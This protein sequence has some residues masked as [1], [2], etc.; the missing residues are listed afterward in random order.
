MAEMERVS[1]VSKNAIALVTA[2]LATSGLSF[3]MAIIINKQLGP[4]L[5]GVYNFAFVIYMI[6]QV[7]PDFGIGN[8][9]IRDVSQD[10]AKLHYYFRN[11]VGLR[12][13]LGLAAFILLTTTNLITLAAQSPGGIGAEKFWAVFVIGFCFFIEQ[14]FS[15][16]LVENFIAL[17]RLTVVA[18]VYLV[19]GILKVGL[20]IYVV[21][22]GFNN[23]V[24]W[25]ILIY[26]FTLLYSV[27]HF[28]L[29]YSRLLK[30]QGELKSGTW[31]KAAAA[32]LLKVPETGEVPQEALAAE[33]A[34]ASAMAAET[35]DKV[36]FEAPSSGGAGTA[37]TDPEPAKSHT[38]WR[39]GRFFDRELWLYLLRSAWP[40]AVVSSAITIYAIVDVPILSWMKGD[41]VVGLYAAAAM[42]A[43]AF[44][45]LTIAINMAVLPA[46]SKVGGKHPEKLGPTWEKLLFYCVVVIAPLMV[47]TP[48]LARPVL[49][50]EGFDYI[51]AW[52][53]VWLSMAAMV[54]TFMEA[55]SFSFFIVI[56]KQKKITGIIIIGLILKAALDLIVIPLWSYTGMA[57]I[58]VVSEFLVFMMIF[59]TL[60]RELKHKINLLKF[61]AAP[62]GI[63][64]ILYLTALLLHNFLTIGKDTA[65][66]AAVAAVIASAIVAG[67]YFVLAYGIGFLRKSRLRELN[68]LLKVE[69]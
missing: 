40:L 8:I 6:F 29:I 17:E 37:T 35:M 12:M 32:A 52:V 18:L 60:S 33:F 38:F 2:K 1:R 62:V 49:I 51:D 10:N 14:P 3:F 23:V 63:L 21:L 27:A 11:V 24:V 41:E 22:A 58:V 31:D 68:D 56:N 4:V 65:G 59:Y 39:K 43:K 47:L 34:L 9:S 61:A 66:S 50:L 7:L 5:V 36:Q 69:D 13:L 44:V 46:V 55:I 54:F 25:L 48:I 15:N 53:V 67:L 19:V 16:T 28:Y 30:R 26:I 57:V 20:S 45:F 64:G 42:F